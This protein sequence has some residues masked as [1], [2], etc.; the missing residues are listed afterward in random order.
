MKL[1]YFISLIIGSGLFLGLCKG[2]SLVL[3]ISLSEFIEMSFISP[4]FYSITGIV[5][6][7]ML[8]LCSLVSSFVITNS[9]KYERKFY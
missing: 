9:I 1:I 5:L 7:G 8:Y 3:G 2:L 4:D 6:L